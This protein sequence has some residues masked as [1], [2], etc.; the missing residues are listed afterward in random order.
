MSAETTCIAAISSIDRE[1]LALGDAVTPLSATQV[2]SWVWLPSRPTTIA[3]VSPVP[4]LASRSRLSGSAPYVQV[5]SMRVPHLV[6]LSLTVPLTHVGT[7]RVSVRADAL[8][9]G[10]PGAGIEDLD[11][12]ATKAPITKTA[13]VAATVHISSRRRRCQRFTLDSS[14]SSIWC[15]SGGGAPELWSPPSSR[16]A[17]SSRFNRASSPGNP[18]SSLTAAWHDAQVLRCFELAAVIARQ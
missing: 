8:A 2:A 4:S 17:T 9:G 12:S 16:A 3:S 5:I 11:G 6:L 10:G 15:R 7:T 1:V 18:Q 13:A 14:D